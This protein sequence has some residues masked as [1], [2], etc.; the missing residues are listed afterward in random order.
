M[1]KLIIKHTNNVLHILLS[2]SGN[3]NKSKN[4]SIE[5]IDFLLQNQRNNI[6][7]KNVDVNHS[8][9]A[10]KFEKEVNSLLKEI[11]PLVERHPSKKRTNP[12]GGSIS[13]FFW[14]KIPLKKRCVIEGIFKGP[15]FVSC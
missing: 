4:L 1:Q 9:I 12:L 6:F 11:V 5:R 7:Q 10:H 2:K 8:F 15:W 14:L 13:K 3:W